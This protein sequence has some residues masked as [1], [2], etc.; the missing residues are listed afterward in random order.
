MSGGDAIPEF[1]KAKSG[2]DGQDVSLTNLS[3]FASGP[4]IKSGAEVAA[5]L[6]VAVVIVGGIELALRIFHVPQYIMPPP[7]SIAYALFDEFP[8]I[9]PHL[10]YTLVELVSGFAVGAMV[11][12][13]MA[14]VI[15]QFPFAEKIVAPYILILV[16]TPMLA[17]VPLLILRFGFG[18]TPRIIAVALAAGPMVMINAATGFRRVDSAKIALARSY[19]ASTLQ[20]FWKIRA[21]MALPMILVGLMIGAIFGLLTA[22]GAEMVGGG[23]GLG[24]R[25]TS[26]S[27]MIQMPQFFAVVLIL[28]TLGILIY[29][30]FFLIGK[31]WAS[32]ET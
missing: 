5:I 14:A 15:T 18:Y 2:G 30:L 21:P 25:L 1:S 16:T 11:G 28:S 23:F 19:G 29:V 20:I 32:W 10:G 3:A 9:A 17:L 27:S 26:Y 24:N 4:G 22:V 31:K 13:V 12:L 8:L 6:A 7:S